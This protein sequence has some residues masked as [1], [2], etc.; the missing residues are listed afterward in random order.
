MSHGVRIFRVDN[1]HTKSVPFWERL[2]GEIRRTD[3]DVVFLAEAFTTPPMMRAL[4][5]VG[6]QQSYSYFTWR[7]SKQDIE[8]YFTEVAQETPAIVRPN[9]FVNTPDILHAFLQ[10]GGPPAFKIRAVLAATGSPSWGVYAGFELYEHV[11]V[12]PGSE[13]YLDSEKYQLRIRDWEAADVEGRTLAPYI[14]NLNRLRREHPA[15]QQLRNL[16]VHAT[17]DDATVCYTKQAVVGD[18]GSDTVIVVVNLDPHGTRETTVHLDLPALGLDW[19]DTFA[20]HD[21]I[22]GEAF[23]WGAQNYVRLDPFWEPAH[24]LVVRRGPVAPR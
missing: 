7:T 24:V 15:L 16:R 17:D 9:F 18:P 8:E 23:E 19:S 14:T 21:E 10:Y 22:G 2:L 12:R 5:T 20:V 4:G 13:E 3:P 6:Y 11:A 1:P